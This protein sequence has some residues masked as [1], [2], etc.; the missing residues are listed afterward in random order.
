MPFIVDAGELISLGSKPF[1][2]EA[3]ELIRYNFQS[4]LKEFWVEAID[5]F[6]DVT[7][8]VESFGLNDS[9]L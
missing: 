2:V 5:T 9:V 3:D 7:K 8:L 1:I 4:A 6:T